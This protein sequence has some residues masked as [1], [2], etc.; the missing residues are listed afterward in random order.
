V[1]EAIMT[2]A[3]ESFWEN[4]DR[5]Y[6]AYLDAQIGARF[7]REKIVEVQAQASA[8]VGMRLERMDSLPFLYGDGDPN[9]PNTVVLHQVPQ[10]QFKLR[11]R[12][13]GE[14]AQFL[15]SMSVVAIFQFWE[16]K[17]RSE[18]ASELG[19]E[20]SALKHDLLGD[21]R[22]IRMAI[23]HS[24]SVAKD[25]IRRGV[26]LQWFKPGDLIV[27]DDGRMKEIVVQIREACQ[28]WIAIREAR[29]T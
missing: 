10:G 11:N 19:I 6:G 29:R 13:N 3:V 26:R 28:D 24:G 12:R 14:N 5:V 20:R 22:R 16:D 1:G 18:I 9:D 27:I 23:I 2:G 17:Y 7:F 8:L 15:G 25:E 21:L 4:V